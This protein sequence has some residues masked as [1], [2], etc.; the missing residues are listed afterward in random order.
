MP[1]PAPSPLFDLTGRVIIVTGATGVLA[2]SAARYLVAQGA[3]VV[4]LGRDQTK[5]DAARAD[6]IGLPGEAVAY[7][8]DVLDRTGLENVRA[9][10]VARFGRI[11]ALINAA[12][13]STPPAPP[14]PADKPCST[15]RPSAAS[16]PPPSSTAHSTSSS[17]TPPPSSPAPSSP[18]TA[19]SPAS[20]ACNIVRRSA[21]RR[22]HASVLPQPHGRGHALV[23]PR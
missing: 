7:S 18:L 21:L 23:R 17:P 14:P 16:A 8:V 12:C 2:G 4:F 13:S 6:C 10:V 1:T 3:R 15:K 5:L 20:R 22:S 11:D 9:E 19:A